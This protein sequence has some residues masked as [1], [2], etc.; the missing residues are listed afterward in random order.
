MVIFG[1][2]T[3]GDVL[4]ES[5]FYIEGRRVRYLF[6]GVVGKIP[7]LLLHGARFNADTWVKTSTLE[8]L[9]LEGYSTYAIDLPS[10]GK[11]DEILGI[12]STLDYSEFLITLLSILKLNR[13]IL[14]GPSLGGVIALMF[15][16]KHPDHVSGLVL[17]G[18]AGPEVEEV[19]PKLRLLDIPTLIIWGE[20]D[21][22]VPMD[23]AIEL[24]SVIKGSE[25][26]VIEGGSHP[27]YIDNP[28]SFNKKLIEFLS[29]LK[30]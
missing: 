26:F 1:C 23:L 2:Q 14:V 17:I 11:S 21:L 18:S 3:A 25:L 27:C 4:E 24:H 9:T 5:F 28:H 20:R 19:K 12:N 30:A 16:T 10:F 13:V 29:S 7:I 6:N 8:I 15:A 22:V